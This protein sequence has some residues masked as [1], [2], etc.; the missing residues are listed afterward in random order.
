MGQ[1]TEGKAEG[2]RQGENPEQNTIMTF[3]ING[4]S[5]YMITIIFISTIILLGILP[6][7]MK[8]GRNFLLKIIALEQLLFGISLT[9]AH[10][11]FILDDMTGI[12]VSQLV[13][14]LAGSESAIALSILI[15][16]YP[17]RGTL[18]IT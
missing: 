3:L 14:P 5:I 1:K 11:S 8:N 15:N 13:L 17:R 4:I 12:L 2:W 10:F 9:F 16:Y 7:R 6:N 18:V